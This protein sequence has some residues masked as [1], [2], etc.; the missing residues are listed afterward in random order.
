VPYS[1]VARWHQL[2]QGVLG[3]TAS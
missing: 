3:K 2:S 1:E